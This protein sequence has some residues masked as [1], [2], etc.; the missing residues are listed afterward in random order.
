MQEHEREEYTRLSSFA[1]QYTLTPEALAK[2]AASLVPEEN[3]GCYGEEGLEAKLMLLPMEVYVCGKPLAMGGIAGVATWPEKRRG[4][5]VGE[6]LSH[7]LRIMKDQGQ[8]ISMLHP[9]KFE[10]YRRFGWETYTE[11]KKLELA[12][13][14][15]PRFPA[16]N[17]RIVRTTE[18]DTLQPVYEAYAARYNGMLVR[19]RQWWEERILAR[20]NEGGLGAVFLDGAGLPKG[21]ILY[22]VAAHTLTIHEWVALDRE[23]YRGLWNFVADHDSML[24]NEGK[25]QVL[26]AHPGDRLTSLLK[27]PRIRQETVPYF[28]ARLVDAEA[29]LNG[30]SFRQEAKGELRLHIS[31]GQA[32]WNDGGYIIRLD[33]EGTEPKVRRSTA[34]DGD[35]SAEGLSC[36]IGILTSM[37]LGYERPSFWHEHGLLTGSLSQLELLEAALPEGKPFLLDF[38]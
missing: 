6:L 4:G 19:S 28:M 22:K 7:S 1:F 5:R 14:Q 37:L 36:G 26:M 13:S 35:A 34:V 33:E 3:W 25:V 38:F 9:F 12:P 23:A 29:F 8:T 10:F 20:K 24:G 31:D 21:Y 2:R 18:L 32:S 27:D 30:Y 16:A 11:Y 17:G 15:L